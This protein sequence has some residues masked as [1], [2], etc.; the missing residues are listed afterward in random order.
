MVFK[1]E[2]KILV[3]PNVMK[4]FV[5]VSEN[6]IKILSSSRTFP[7]LDNIYFNMSFWK[8]EILQQLIL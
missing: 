3:Q 5:K 4:M 1:I 7:E 8:C 6:Y 2:W